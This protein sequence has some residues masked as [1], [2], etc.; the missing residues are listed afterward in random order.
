MLGGDPAEVPEH[1]QARITQPGVG[2]GHPVATETVDARGH[3]GWASHSGHGPAATLEQV[4][5]GRFRPAYVVSVHVGEA[6]VVAEGPPGQHHGHVEPW[7]VEWALAVHAHQH[8]AVHMTAAQVPRCDLLVSWRVCRE[9]DRRD[10]L[11]QQLPAAA[12]EHE[13]EE[14]FTED[15]GV[16][17]AHHER[18]RSGAPP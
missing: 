11:R 16:V 3:V 5:H 14:R 9:Q 6:G 4:P 13:L 17:F 18:D 15:P 12:P 1:D 8:G 2:H 7:D 10:A